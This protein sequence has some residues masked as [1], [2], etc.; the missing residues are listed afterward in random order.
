ML[1]R[2][3]DPP[4]SSQTDQQLVALPDSLRCL[5]GELARRCGSLLARAQ[6]APF[7]AP[8][9]Y[10]SAYEGQEVTD[11]Q[12][13]KKSD[14]WAIEETNFC[15]GRTSFIR[16]KETDDLA[17]RT[18]HLMD[19]QLNKQHTRLRD[20]TVIPYTA[21]FLDD[22]VDRILQLLFSFYGVAVFEITI[23]ESF[24]G[25]MKEAPAREAGP[26]PHFH[27]TADASEIGVQWWSLPN[28]T[29]PG[30]PAVECRGPK[31]REGEERI[32]ASAVILGAC[33]AIASCCVRGHFEPSC[34]L[35]PFE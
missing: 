2:Y 6:R 18:K 28:L 16:Y 34:T 20:G 8:L 4:V 15:L 31:R 32:G 27:R 35:Y 29:K 33:L 7:V 30:C 12:L 1:A 17:R 19:C 13:V 26:S 23:E 5:R 14:D 10:F 3:R 21:L 11:D 22:M 24:K 9:R 25:I